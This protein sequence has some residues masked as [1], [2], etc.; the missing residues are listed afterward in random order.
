MLVSWLWLSDYVALKISP[1]ELAHRFAM[2][3]LNHEQ[4][5]QEGSDTVLDLEVTSNRGDCLGHIGVAR[6]AAVLLRQQLCI[7]NPQPQECATPTSQSIQLE[8]RFPEGCT[9]YMARIIRGVKV[10]PSPDWLVQRLKSIGIKSVNNVVDVTNYVMMEC[11]QP[12]HAFDLHQIRGKKI[13]IRAAADGEQFVAID[14]RTYQLDSQT[15]VIADAERAVALGGVMGG[16]DSEISS[17]TTDVLLETALFQP[18]SIRRTAR[19]LKLQSPSSF[20]FERRPDPAGVDWASR[21][22]CELMLQ[23]AGGRLEAGAIS[24]GE[25][26]TRRPTILL[27]LSQIPRLLGVDIAQDHVAD[28]LRA[29][30]CLVVPAEAGLEVTPPGWRGDLTREV[31]LVEEVARIYGYERI[32][33]D[34]AVPMS[35]VKPR[36]KDIAVGRI[37]HALSAYGID[38]AMTPSVVTDKME[39]CGSLW[40]AQ[41]P[42][43][44]ETPLL[45]GARLLRRSIIPSLLTARQINQTQSIRNAQLYE[46][47]NVVLPKSESRSLPD[48]L[49][50]LGMVTAGDLQLVKGIVQAIVQQLGNEDWVLWR[51]AE[52][53]LFLSGSAQSLT[54]QD[55]SVGWLGVVSPI[56]QERFDLDAACCAA[57]LDVDVLTSMLIEIREAKAYSLFPAIERDLNFVVEEPLRWVELESTCRRHGGA[58]LLAV[59][60]RET[61]RDAKKDGSGKKR[62]LLSLHFQSMDRTLTGEQVDAAVATVV[63]A[64]QREHGA[65]LLA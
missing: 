20:R 32:P 45:E 13:I 3:G 44:T 7:P 29:L 19:R 2:S 46:I 14:H 62:I 37:R 43:S 26:E 31:D 25:T 17:A 24:V 6:E 55:R 41:P 52:H 5:I 18:L 65:T 53:P 61:Y 22:C 40:T 64:C 1:D 21:R 60:Y 16:A 47:A 49:T 42:L 8:N 54:I 30:G 48:E 36:R 58:E 57:E 59:S 28:I 63:G 11:G 39:S 10:G 33:E 50:L 4:T 12:L 23:V 38:E 9:R 15:I 34:V 51:D 56:V 27:R 35:V